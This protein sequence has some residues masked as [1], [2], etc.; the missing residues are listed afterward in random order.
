MSGPTRWCDQPVVSGIAIDL[1]DAGEALQNPFSMNASATGRVGEGNTWRII[2]APW[3][4]IPCQRPEVS[5]LGFTRAWIKNRSTCL[6]HEQFGRALQIGNK[7]I[8]DW[9]QFE[10]CSPDPVGKCGPVEIDAL[11]AHDLSLPIQRK[12]IG[13]FR[14]QNMGDGRLRR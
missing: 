14:D 2:A 11:S 13:I 10:R 4:I 6:V 8:E 7:R 12:M 1:Q 3:A 9:T 5:G